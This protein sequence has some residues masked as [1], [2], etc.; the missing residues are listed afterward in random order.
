MT[1]DVT[2][3][4]PCGTLIGLSDSVVRLAD[5]LMLLQLG[6][7]LVECIVDHGCGGDQLVIVSISMDGGGRPPTGNTQMGSAHV[8]FPPLA[9]SRSNT[10][11]KAVPPPSNRPD[12]TQSIMVAMTIMQ[13]ITKNASRR[14]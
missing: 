8:R 6:A 3:S 7:M 9:S 4:M 12:L 11:S 2:T 5:P 10:K 1:M 13:C 14:G